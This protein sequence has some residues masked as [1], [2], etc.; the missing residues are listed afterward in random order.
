[1]LPFWKGPLDWLTSNEDTDYPPMDY[2]TFK[3]PAKPGKAVNVWTYIRLDHLYEISEDSSTIKFHLTVR[4]KWNDTRLRYTPS[5]P[6]HDA[7]NRIVKPES[8]WHP[9]LRV[10][11]ER[12]HMEPLETVRVASSGE[13]T[14]TAHYDSEVWAEI[15]FRYID[16]MMQK[17]LRSDIHSRSQ[18]RSAL[19][20]L[21]L[22][23]IGVI[24]PRR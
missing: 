12:G 8:I 23:S 13:V 2:E 7:R 10:L 9:L 22:G 5:G 1:M 19:A 20:D 17:T 14:Y 11:K 4:L 24:V 6:S 15:D 16:Y 21:M 18:I 3:R